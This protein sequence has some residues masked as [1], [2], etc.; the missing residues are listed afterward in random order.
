M[1]K[2]LS[3]SDLEKLSSQDLK[4]SELHKDQCWT[5][6]REPILPDLCRSWL[7]WDSWKKIGVVHKVVQVMTVTASGGGYIVDFEDMAFSCLTFIEASCAVNSD[8]S[9]F[10][11][12]NESACALIE[13]KMIPVCVEEAQKF[14]RI[15]DTEGAS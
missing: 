3:A 8:R 14:K 6:M 7:D 2:M 1:R 12:A 11:D 15:Q 4:L 13:D 9:F 10:G 5:E